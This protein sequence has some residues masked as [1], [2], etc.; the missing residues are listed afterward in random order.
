MAGLVLHDATRLA[1]AFDAAK[2]F[3][4]GKIMVLGQSLGGNHGASAGL[5][6]AMRGLVLP[7]CGAVLGELPEARRG[8]GQ[9]C[10]LVGGSRQASIAAACID[11][12]NRT[13]IA[14]ERIGGRDL[15]LERDQAKHLERRRQ[16]ATM[17]GGHR[18]QRQ[19]QP[20]G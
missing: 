5:L 16:F 15:A 3:Q 18:G 7:C 4:A 1:A 19:A 17:V 20:R 11:R 13:A 9:R 8:V 14:M 12:C 10:V 2:G 6:A